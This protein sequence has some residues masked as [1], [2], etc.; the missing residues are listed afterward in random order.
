MKRLI[1]LTCILLL[2]GASAASAL[3]RFDIVTTE[4]VQQMLKNRSAG[5]TDLILVNCL[6][7]MI[8]RHAAIPGSVNIPL[9]DI[10]ANI[11]K[12]GKDKN[13]KIVTY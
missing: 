9:G 10:P 1:I 3:E 8:Y 13:I 6:D 12:L 11:H 7:A 2:C 5:L 4:E